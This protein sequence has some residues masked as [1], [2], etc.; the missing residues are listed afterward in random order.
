DLGLSGSVDAHPAAQELDLALRDIG[1]KLVVRAPQQ[2]DKKLALAIASIELGRHADALDVDIGKLGVG[3]VGLDHAGAHFRLDGQR[4]AGAQSITLAGL[5]V[6]DKELAEL[7]G[8]QL[9]LNDLKV[10]LSVTGPANHL[11]IGGAVKTGEAKLA[12]DGA[13]DATLPLKPS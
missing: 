11:V 4:L 3:G 2:Q 8:K 13:V 7:L 5:R 12:I 9:L 1:A 6:D 10:D